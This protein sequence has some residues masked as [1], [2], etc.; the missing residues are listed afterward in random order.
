MAIAKV[1]EGTDVITSGGGSQTV[2]LTGSIQEGDVTIIALSGDTDIVPNGEGIDTSEGYTDLYL[3]GAGVTNPGAQ[4]AYKVM[5]ATPDTS[6]SVNRDGSLRYPL[7][8]QV[9]RGADPDN[10][11][12]NSVDSA[13][14]ASGLPNPP[15]HTTLTAGA[16]R[17]VIGFLDDDASEGLLTAPTGYSNLLDK[18]PADSPNDSTVMI[19]SKTAATAGAEDPA[20]FTGTGNDEWS[21]IHFALRPLPVSADGSASGSSTAS[22]VGASTAQADGSSAGA[23]TVTGLSTI[24]LDADGASSG[25]ATVAGV[26]HGLFRALASSAGTSQAVAEGPLQ[27]DVEHTIVVDTSTRTLTVD[28]VS[29]LAVASLSRVVTHIAESRTLTVD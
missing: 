5:G 8:W 15:S 20:A 9:W 21:A 27:A 13:T 7:I 25:V 18:D 26:G 11:I 22:A 6:V 3:P 24:T 19:A 17:V 23:A 28:D 10:P 2:T 16:L 1:S 14:G 12:D 29:A 4:A